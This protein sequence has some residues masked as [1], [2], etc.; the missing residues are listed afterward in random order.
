MRN[1]SPKFLFILIGLLTSS[2]NGFAQQ[3]FND[4]D[5]T[6]FCIGMLD[7][8][9]LRVPEHPKYKDYVAGFN[10]EQQYLIP[11]FIKAIKRIPDLDPISL[12][13]YS[14][15]ATSTYILSSSYANY[16]NDYFSFQPY[17]GSDKMLEG[18]AK[19]SKFAN[20]QQQTSFIVGFVISH[21]QKA[22]DGKY[23]INL[24][25]N[26][27]FLNAMISLFNANHFVIDQSKTNLEKGDFY[28][29]IPDKFQNEIDAVLAVKEKQAN[30]CKQ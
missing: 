16:V 13:L 26:K 6:S 28:F 11:Y 21:A 30:F 12:Q 18:V 29:T 9:R 25:Y 27:D 15:T 2:M 8:P 7:S 10:C 22:D 23:F 19:I 24:G 1:I 14:H 4:L 20:E 17:R 5:A 3:N